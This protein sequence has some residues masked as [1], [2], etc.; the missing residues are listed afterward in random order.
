[1]DPMAKVVQLRNKL[2][3]W[4]CENCKHCFLVSDQDQL[5]QICEKCPV[6]DALDAIIKGAATAGRTEA[7]KAVFEEMIDIL[8]GEH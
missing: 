3:E 8:K 6:E 1:M 4:S 2:L 5:E 7:A